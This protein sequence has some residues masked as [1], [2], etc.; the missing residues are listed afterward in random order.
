[1]DAIITQHQYGSV[2]DGFISDGIEFCFQ[3]VH[4]KRCQNKVERKSIWEH[5]SEIHLLHSY[6]L[7]QETI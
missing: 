1:M 6:L 3:S 4:W 7:K 2:D 5:L